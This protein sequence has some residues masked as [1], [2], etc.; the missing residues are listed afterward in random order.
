MYRMGTKTSVYLSADTKRALDEDPRP[1]AELLR[2]ALA[3]KPLLIEKNEQAGFTTYWWCPYP[4]DGGK[5]KVPPGGDH[6]RT[7][8]EWPIRDIYEC[9]ITQPSDA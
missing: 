1:L 8:S 7:D 5:F 2:H 3:V 4:P 9:E 6:W